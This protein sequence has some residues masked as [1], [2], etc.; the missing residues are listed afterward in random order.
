MGLKD[1]F[2]EHVLDLGDA[3]SPAK[4][5]QAPNAPTP[6]PPSLL[7]DRPNYEAQVGNQLDAATVHML[8]AVIAKRA[9]PFTALVETAD[10]L[11]S[12]IT[13][14]A[15]RFKA[16]YATISNGGTRT[17]QSI[18]QG[19]EL[20]CADLVMESKRFAESSTEKFND[21]VTKVRA[22]AEA[23]REVIKSIN[24]RVLALQEQIADA[25]KAVD[26]AN[27]EAAALLVKAETSSADIA[28]VTKKFEQAAAHVKTNL[29]N[30]R[31]YLTSVLV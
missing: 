31:D 3:S 30:K 12:I 4:T 13:D 10:K 28:D 11:T 16:A 29:L 8:E 25:Q 24:A 23:K 1:F 21:R 7:T 17:I 9:T 6:E 14:E 15:T 22:D 19:I 2:K 27:A 18:T 20:H 5:A 26:A